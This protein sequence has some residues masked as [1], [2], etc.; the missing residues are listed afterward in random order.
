MMEVNRALELMKCLG[1]LNWKV[2]LT[3]W[4]WGWVTKTDLIGYAVDRLQSDTD[5][6]DVAVVSLAGAED[7]ND[8]AIRRLLVRLAGGET[9]EDGSELEKWRLARLLELGETDL[10]WDQKVTRLEELGAEFGYPPDMRQCTRYGP[11][12]ASMEAGLASPA[13]L[14]TDPLDAMGHVI[15][16]LKPRLDVG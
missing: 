12:Q 10:E 7:M 8:E 14:S 15:A 3:G 16:G 13:D 1:L 11:S 6:N 9:E 2:L 4:N 5:D